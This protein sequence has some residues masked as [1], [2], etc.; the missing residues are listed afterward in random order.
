MKNSSIWKIIHNQ[1][2]LWITERL[3][4]TKKN[5]TYFICLKNISFSWLILASEIFPIL[6]ICYVENINNFYVYK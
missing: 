6:S 1:N 5:Y 4:K 2:T 3:D